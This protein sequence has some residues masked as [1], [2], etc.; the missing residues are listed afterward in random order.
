MGH[1]AIQ[2]AAEVGLPAGRVASVKI[3]VPSRSG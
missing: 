1:P 2:V 3:P